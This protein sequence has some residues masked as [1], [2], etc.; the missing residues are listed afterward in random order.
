VIKI[1]EVIVD[2]WN[3]HFL[4][5]VRV[6]EVPDVIDVA[7]GEVVVLDDFVDEGLV[8]GLGDDGFVPVV[9]VALPRE[10]HFAMHEDV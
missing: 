4:D 5:E 3:V 2:E 10:L 1:E 8:R 7:E 6:I 9:W